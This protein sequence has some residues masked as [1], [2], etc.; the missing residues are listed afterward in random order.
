MAQTDSNKAIQIE[1][2]AADRVVWSGQASEVVARTVEGD[3]GV[4]AGHAPLLSVL[5][6]G[7]VEIHPLEGDVVR[8]AVGEGFLSVADD[9]V[10]VLSEDA[11]LASEV[12][13]AAVKAE[14]EE[15]TSAEDSAAV[16]RAEAKLRLIDKA[17]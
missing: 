2:V 15:A 1:L 14:L 7:V 12:D 3:L 17:S 4:L 9:H 5:V 10:S 6:P 11:V 13:A 8:A 16:L